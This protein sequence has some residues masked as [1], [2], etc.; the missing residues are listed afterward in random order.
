MNRSLSSRASWLCIVAVFG[1]VPIHGSQTPETAPSPS[2]QTLAESLERAYKLINTEQ[3]QEA[4]AEL[5]RAA[6]LA[7]GPCGECLLGLS[8]V[9]ESERKWE[10]AVEAA[11]RAIPLLSSSTLQARAY[12]QL[13][14]VYMV[15]RI[16]DALG[17]A[18]DALRRGANL[19]GGWGAMARYHL[20]EVLL[21][22][23]RWRDALET[24]RLYLK[25]PGPEPPSKFIKQAHVFICWSRS[26]LPREPAPALGKETEPIQIKEGKEGEVQRPELLFQADPQYTEQARAAGTTGT[27]IVEAIID[28]EGCVTN[29]RPLQELPNGL[30]E[31]A[32]SAVSKWAFSPATLE[33]QPVKVYYIL[34][35]NFSIDYSKPYAP[36]KRRRP[37][38]D[39][40]IRLEPTLLKIVYA[41]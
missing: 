20:A 16:P 18:E 22:Q 11:Q 21:M 12:D 4:K 33:G 15:M 23:E 36:E 8:Y 7:A 39:L 38:D 26:R 29:V 27:V 17:K 25:E 6:A 10:Q 5:E 14:M 9:Y 13:G 41:G 40:S 31:S 2:P 28:A 32:M 19:G 35:I 37:G 1:A 24:A 3:F 34:T 30:T